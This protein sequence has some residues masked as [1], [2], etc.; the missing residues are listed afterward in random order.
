MSHFRLPLT[1]IHSWAVASQQGARR[2]AMVAA[3]DLAARR[4][5]LLDV[6][7]FIVAATQ[8]H[9]ALAAHA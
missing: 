9:H 8:R 5:E 3:T 2:N 4:A 7:E 6:Q 1:L